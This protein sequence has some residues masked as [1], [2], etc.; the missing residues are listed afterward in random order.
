MKD[1]RMGRSS[2]DYLNRILTEGSRRFRVRERDVM[3]KMEIS[4]LGPQDKA[5]GQLLGA[6]QGNGFF[7]IASRR[8]EPF[9]YP[10]NRKLIHSPTKKYASTQKTIA[11][12]FIISW[13]RWLNPVVLA[14]WEMEIGKIVVQD[15]PGQKVHKIPSQQKKQ[16]VVVCSCHPQILRKA[17]IGGLWSMLAQT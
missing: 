14:T 7:P 4:N 3:M 5:C 1:P 9:Y 17:Q 11:S 16:G 15:Q 10:D 13:A 6:K 12:D 2:W 8:V